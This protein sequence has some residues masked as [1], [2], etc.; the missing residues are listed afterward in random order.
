MKYYVE[1]IEQT[2]IEGTYN[3]YAATTRKFDEFKP[4]QTYFLSRLSEISNS[5]AHTYAQYVIKNSKGAEVG[6]PYTIG[7]YVDLDAVEE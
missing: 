6:K 2:L 5:A 1:G 4:A 3:E 7:E